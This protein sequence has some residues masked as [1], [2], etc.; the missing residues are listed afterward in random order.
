[1]KVDVRIIAA[2]N[3]DLYE[4]IRLGRFR[5][6]L[7]YRLNIFPI[8]VPPLRDRKEDIPLLVD[9][10]LDKFNRKLGK[11]IRNVTK[12][13]MDDLMA[14]AWPGNVRE[15]ESV[16]ERAVIISRGTTLQVLDHF[17]APHPAGPKDEVKPLVDLERDYISQVLRKTNWRI[18]GTQGAARILGINPSTLRGRMRKEG[19]HRP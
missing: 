6:D 13:T 10:F 14:H 8:T 9:Y 7:F 1:M 15:L 17:D 3:R 12:G 11:N 18:E 2:T 5:E 4:E 19:I 16:I